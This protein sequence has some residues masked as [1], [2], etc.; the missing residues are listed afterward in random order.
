M[1]GSSLSIICEREKTKIPRFVHACLAAVEKR[2]KRVLNYLKILF[3][4]TVG[5]SNFYIFPI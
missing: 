4:L 1:F 5:I 2:G 3:L